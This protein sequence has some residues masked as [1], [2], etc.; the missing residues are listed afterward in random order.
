MRLATPVASDIARHADNKCRHANEKYTNHGCSKPGVARA[1]RNGLTG[2]TAIAIANARHRSKG[3]IVCRLGCYIHHN[4]VT[5]EA[6]LAIST[7]LQGLENR[8]LAFVAKLPDTTREYKVKKN[9]KIRE[10]GIP[11]N[12][13][14]S[15]FTLYLFFLHIGVGFVTGVTFTTHS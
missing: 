14:I 9:A 10:T 6:A 2:F 7:R 5:L 12:S 1:G 4:A 11:N 8:D 3:A 13:W 15:I